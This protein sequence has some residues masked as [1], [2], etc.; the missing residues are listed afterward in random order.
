MS[1]DG[2][3]IVSDFEHWTNDTDDTATAT[4]ACV[5]IEAKICHSHIRTCDTS[6]VRDFVGNP[7]V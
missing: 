6:R 1:A 2:R 5:T 3:V 7:S 4:H